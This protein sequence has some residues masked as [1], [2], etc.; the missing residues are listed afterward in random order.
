MTRAHSPFAVHKIRTVSH[1]LKEMHRQS[2][3]RWRQALQ[4]LDREGFAGITRRV[5]NATSR[6][7]AC[8]GEREFVLPEDVLRAD[9]SATF[10]PSQ[11]GL[12]KG[13]AIRVNWVMTPPSEGSGGHS[14]M[15]RIINH[16]ERNG[17]KN[18]VYLYDVYGV[19]HRYYVETIRSYYRFLGPVL[20]MEE[21]MEDAH[22]VMATAWPTAYAAFNARSAGKRFYFVQDIEPA[23]HPTGSFSL[24]AENTYRMGFYGITAGKWLAEELRARYGMEA[25]HFDFGCDCTNYVHTPGPRPPAVAFYARRETARRGFELGVLALEVLTRKR[26]DVE[27]HLYGETT[28]KLPFA[29]VNHGRLCPKELNLLYGKCRAGLSLSLTNVSLVPHEMLSAGCI[30]VVNDADRNRMVLANPRVVYA[31][32]TPHHL[33]TALNA[34]LSAAD[35]ET[36]SKLAS[37]SVRTTS[38]EE[39]GAKVDQSL[40]SALR[41]VQ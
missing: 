9:L 17:Y 41:P 10:V 8:G 7:L 4:I 21:G 15:F 14:T 36:T 40:R 29:F 31:E 23:F 11:P 30:P 13:E 2:G 18:Q 38:W 1:L 5:R 16:L 6:R 19:D 34:V 24:M 12:A 39:S 20:P 3:R 35:C 22:A 37:L 33:A 28:S 26:K 32:P 25:D 27:I